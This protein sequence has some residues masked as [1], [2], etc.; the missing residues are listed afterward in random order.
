MEKPIYRVEYYSISLFYSMYLGRKA[1]ENNRSKK[2]MWCDS[3]NG[4]AAALLLGCL[5]L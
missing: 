1:R 3:S 2:M 4:L 5:F